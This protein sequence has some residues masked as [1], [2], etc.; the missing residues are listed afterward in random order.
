MGDDEMAREVVH[1]YLKHEGIAKEETLKIYGLVFVGAIFILIFVYLIATPEFRK[2]YYVLVLS[3]LLPTVLIGVAYYYFLK[4]IG[5]NFPEELIIYDNGWFVVW[6]PHDSDGWVAPAK[7]EW[8]LPD[9]TIIK[10]W[11]I[12]AYMLR[13]LKEE[14]EGVLIGSGIH[15]VFPL[16]QLYREYTFYA[17]IYGVVHP[18]KLS[19]LEKMYGILDI[20]GRKNLNAERVWIPSGKPQANWGYMKQ[21][22]YWNTIFKKEGLREYYKKDT[23]EDV[24]EPVRSY[25]YDIRKY[26][27]VYLKQKKETGDW[28]GK[29]NIKKEWYIDWEWLEK[30]L[31]AH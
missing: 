15:W 18:Q 25:L 28:F 21:A 27:K 7:L 3:M 6:G 17:A 23:G 30:W 16:N 31:D 9:K 12:K 13:K 4:R 8:I 1:I 26:K 5:E 11:G 24:P 10:E 2:Y 20:I 29:E 19:C 22:F 14:K